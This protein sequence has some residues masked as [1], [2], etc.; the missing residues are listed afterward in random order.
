MRCLPKRKCPLCLE[1]HLSSFYA[2]ILAKSDLMEKLERER[3][4]REEDFDFILQFLRTVL[5]KRE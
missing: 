1:K 3:A 4:W 5:L 2:E